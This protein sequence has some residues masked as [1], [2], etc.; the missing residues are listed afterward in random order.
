MNH[1]HVSESSSF[2]LI[3]KFDDKLFTAFP[4]ISSNLEFGK[5]YKDYKKN[6]KK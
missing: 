1:Q 5:R 3:I 6:T 4:P 2:I